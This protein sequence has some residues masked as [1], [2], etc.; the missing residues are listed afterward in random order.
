VTA[1]ALVVLGL[2]AACFATRMVLGP[3]LADRVV[4]VNGLLVTGMSAVVAQA[5]RSHTGAF[6][7]ALVVVTLVG[8]V[9]TG[10]VARYLEGRGR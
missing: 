2:A 10:M 9:G 3:T 6:L 4:G 5:V 8:F 1:V 7:P